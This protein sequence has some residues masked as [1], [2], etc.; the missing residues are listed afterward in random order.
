MPLCA[1]VTVARHGKESISVAIDG[2]PFTEFFFGPETTK[3]YLHPLRSASGKMVSRGYP[4]M[5]IPGES[6]DHPHQRGLWFSHGEVNGYDFWANEKSQDNGKKGRIVL[7][8][9]DK[10]QSGKESGVIEATFEWLDPQ[11]KAIMTES[12]K[13][14]FYSN[15]TLRIM[16]FDIL[17]KP[18]QKVTFGDTKE[19]SF[20]IRIAA[21]LEEPQKKSLP[22]PKRTGKMINAQGKQGETQVWG[23]RS[24]WVDY[25]GELEGEKLGIAIFDNPA[26][27]RHPTYWHSRSYG[28]FA[29]NIFGEREFTKDKSRD[30]SMTIE[31]GQPLEFRYRVIIHP[32]DL[33]SAHIGELYKEYAAGK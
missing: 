30:G 15:P 33:Q 22:E 27:P 4:M 18:L 31:P 25:S 20:A 12:R 29:A 21:G 8:K 11:G 14:V 32:G 2:K 5:D 24:E 23:Q 7:K 28:L 17:L 13:M 19:G 6:K 26:N 1:Q 3:P 9:I 16:D 10:V